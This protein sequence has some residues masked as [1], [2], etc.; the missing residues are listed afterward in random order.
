MVLSYLVLALTLCLAGGEAEG[1]MLE[2]WLCHLTTHG[3]GM[4]LLHGGHMLL[5]PQVSDQPV[6]MTRVPWPASGSEVGPHHS[7]GAQCPS[8]GDRELPFPGGGVPPVA[9]PPS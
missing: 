5:S 2:F 9:C 6:L 7:Q 3:D 1:G 8:P 4:T